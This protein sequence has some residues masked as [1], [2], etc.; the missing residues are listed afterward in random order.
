MLTMA[1]S[2]AARWLAAFTLLLS[3]PT[4]GGMP[5]LSLPYQLTSLTY[6]DEASTSTAGA[7]LLRSVELD[8]HSDG[9][10]GSIASASASASAS[11]ADGHY[12]DPHGDMLAVLRDPTAYFGAALLGRGCHKAAEHSLAIWSI[13]HLGYYPW[14][15]EPFARDYIADTCFYLCWLFKVRLSKHARARTHLCMCPLPPPPPS[16]P[17]E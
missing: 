5:T 10:E 11:S 8:A 16:V 17:D 7:T 14:L 13:Y 6:L 4:N 1:S 2:T 12:D 15:A 3:L 9:A